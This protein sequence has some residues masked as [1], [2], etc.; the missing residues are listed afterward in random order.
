VRTDPPTVLAG[1]YVLQEE[2]G[3]SKLGPAWRATD[4]VL[5]RQV[6]VKLIPP[7]IAEDP[8]FAQQFASRARTAALL[9]HP[10]FARLLDLGSDEG[11]AFLVREYIAGQSLRQLLDTGGPQPPL[12]AARLVA[13]V[14]DALSEVRDAG[15]Q[16][17]AITAENVI[18]SDDGSIRLTDAAVSHVHLASV[19]VPAPT[20]SGVDSDTKAESPKLFPGD[21]ASE[22]WSAGALLFELLTGRRPFDAGT[23]PRAV[24]KKVPRELDAAVAKALTPKPG[25]RFDSAEEFARALR[26]VVD[27]RR[28]GPSPVQPGNGGD[29]TASARAPSAG[30]PRST[31]RTWLAVPLLVATVAAIATAVGLSLGKLELGGPVGIRL[32]DDAPR[33]SVQPR[34]LRASVT[35]YD[36]LGDGQENDSGASYAND[37][38]PA[39]AWKSENY[40]DGQL[41]KPGVGLLLDLGSSHT[42]TG[43]RLETPY[44]GF[45]FR[46]EV[47]DDPSALASETGPTMTATSDDRR[48]IGPASGRY[49]LVWFTTIVPVNDGHRVEIAEFHVLGT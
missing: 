7:T 37:G 28:L 17:P 44:P 18:V 40:F 15:L 5:D 35:A 45:E 30:E 13:F 10:G 48:T 49:V 2:L 47:G 29:I 42:V 46:V 14:L 6:V 32:K 34:V 8:D 11:V 16:H 4:L 23:S 26:R 24:R 12:E 21:A 43:F 39:T 27:P 38:N 20:P 1:R 36:P 31:F 33:A 22:V 3:R 41:H 19:E 9:S 25:D